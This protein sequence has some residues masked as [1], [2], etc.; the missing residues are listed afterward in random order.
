ME[1]AC[2]SQHPSGTV[3]RL[4]ATPNAARSAATGLVPGSGGGLRLAVRV[5][6]P[7]VE[8]QA[9]EAVRHWAA[10]AFGLRPSKVGILRGERSREKDLLLEGIDP[11]QAGAILDAMLPADGSAGSR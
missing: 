4:R 2:L 11:E 5:Q 6:A 9:N 7:P 1:R 3:L 8:G 10:E